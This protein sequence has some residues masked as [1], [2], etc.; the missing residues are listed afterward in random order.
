MFGIVACLLSI[1]LF[2]IAVIVLALHNGILEHLFHVQ[3]SSCK[4]CI[5]PYILSSCRFLSYYI[6]GCYVRTKVVKFPLFYNE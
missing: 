5:L 1:K 2:V 6:W 4:K 3:T